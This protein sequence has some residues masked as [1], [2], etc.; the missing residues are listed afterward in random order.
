MA[1]GLQAY[2]YLHILSDMTDTADY[3]LH[4]LTKTTPCKMYLSDDIT[5]QLHRQGAKVEKRCLICADVM[6]PGRNQSRNWSL[7]L[8]L[9]SWHQGRW[10]L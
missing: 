5:T 1:R 6:L 2:V 7:S 8:R 3:F 9:I 4:L 10:R